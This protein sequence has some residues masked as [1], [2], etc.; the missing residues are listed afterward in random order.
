MSLALKYQLRFW[1]IGFAV[2]FAAVFLLRAVLLPFVAGMAV[3][4]LLD[5]LC[6]RLGRLGLSRIWATSLVTAGFVVAVTVGLLLLI[7]LLIGQAAGL[8]E[9]LPDYV[10]GLREQ[11]IALAQTIE[12][13]FDPELLNRVKEAIAGTAKQALVLTT[14]VL[15]QLLSGGVAVANLLSLLIITPVVAFY[16]LRD[17]DHLIAQVDS[18]LPRQADE[19]VRA[20]IAKVDRIL[21]GFVRGQSTVCALLGLFYAIGLTLAG[22]EFGLVVGLLAG[23]LSFIPFVGSAVGFVCSFGLAL[24]QFD[25]W[26]RIA[27]VVAI[28]VVGQLVE[29]NFLTPK[30]V[31]DRVGLHP[32]WVIFALLAG[33]TLFGFLGVLLA[34]PLAAVLGVLVRYLLGRY[35]ESGYYLGGGDA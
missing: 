27:V 3:A 4:Y 2:F 7:P 5:P 10:E 14:K 24:V 26:P 28:F 17:W 11:A 9:R 33:G 35:L 30:L 21:A 13:R 32:V 29:G 23:L 15:G 31:G 1:L 16:L 18:W 34:V 12:A 20:E 6:D 25:D 8:I 19:T 22:L